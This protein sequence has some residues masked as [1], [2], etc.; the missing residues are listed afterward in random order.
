MTSSGLT[1]SCEE[2]F[3]G[4]ICGPILRA[5]PAH[6]Y[7]GGRAGSAS[8]GGEYFY[9]GRNYGTVRFDWEEE[10]EGEMG[11]KGGAGDPAGTMTVLVHDE[12]GGVV[13]STGGI[14]LSSD[15]GPVRGP[16]GAQLAGLGGCADGRLRPVAGG[17][18]LALVLA[19]VLLRRSRR[20]GGG[21]GGAIRRGKKE[22]EG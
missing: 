4:T 7:R 2:A 6:R 9:T 3:Y 16:T 18:M 1:H 22:K 14:G 13:L 21:G 8:H 11:G 19:A 10:G 17:G 15:P 12:R 20:E 5:Y